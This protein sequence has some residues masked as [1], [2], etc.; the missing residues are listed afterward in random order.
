MKELWKEFIDFHKKRDPF[1]TRTADG[2][3]RFGEFV[4][5]RIE[6]EDWLVLVAE[7]EGEVVGH[8]LATIEEY[9]PVY[10]NPRYGYVQDIAV[11]KKYRRSRI[12]RKFFDR[13]AAWFREQGVDRIELD[14][15][16][17]NDVSAR[18]WRE[19]GFGDF[20]IRMSKKV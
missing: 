6:K 8:C 16:A 14:V 9:P 13:M 10:I 18:F 17:T 19:I 20:M 4:L 12:G 5:E 11:T 2:H 7:S 3:D 15:T 1:F